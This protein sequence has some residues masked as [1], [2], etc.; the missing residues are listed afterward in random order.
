MKRLILLLIACCFSLT[1]SIAYV[2]ICP[3]QEDGNTDLT[4]G[5][6]RVSEINIDGEWV[7][8]N[9]ENYTPPKGWFVQKC[10]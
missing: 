9:C 4:D 3:I 1:S 10:K 8:A 2:I 5:C 7:E 6:L